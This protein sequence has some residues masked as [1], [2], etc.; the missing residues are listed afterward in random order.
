MTNTTVFNTNKIR[1][2]DISSWTDID[3]FL[4][5]LQDNSP[6]LK[7]F[8]QKEFYSFISTG[9]AFVTYD[10]GI[11]GVSMEIFK[12]AQ[13]LEKILNT[14]TDKIPLHF[15]SGDFY[16]KADVVLKPHWN[17]YRI[18]GMN[19]WS[20]WFDGKW[21][22][23]LFYEEMPEGSAL[24]DEIAVE[25]WHQA[26]GFAEELGSY[27]VKN[28]ISMII[29]V[30]I[31]TNPG[32][33]AIMLAIILV[34]ESL[35]TYIISSNHDYYWEGGKSESDKIPGERPGTRDHFFKNVDNEP[36]FSLF[37]KMYPWNG[38]RWIQ[39]N[40]NT[41][42]TNELV[43]N[44]G[45]DHDRVFELGTAISDAFF[46]EFTEDD[47]RIYRR[48]MAYILSDGSPVIKCIPV[49]EHLSSLK[50]WMSYQHPLVCTY[51]KNLT[52]DPAKEKTIYCLQ[53]TRVVGR[54]RIYMDLEMLKAMIH[55]APFMNVFN[56]DSDYQL[57][58]HITGPVPI[59]HQSDLETVL[60]AYIDLCESLLPNVANRIYLAFSVGTEDHPAL[61]ENKLT[62]LT[63]EQI[64]RMATVVLFPSET[65]GRGLPII[66]SSACGIPIIC[67]RYHPEEVFAEV[68][69]E[70]LSEE[71]QIRYLRFPEE[72]YSERFLN[73]ATE[74]MLYSEKT[75]ELTTHNKKAVRLRYT[76][77]MINAKFE[78]FFNAL[79][80]L[81]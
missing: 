5:N 39:V 41:T 42:Q 56:Q 62:K 79:N 66:E 23:T 37:K 36:F 80:S 50:S 4:K 59:E 18:S 2:A 6:S 26:K 43:N 40:I 21:F 52:L 76:T 9:I 29:P 28:N 73:A 48:K 11:D 20:K 61:K 8:T 22:S 60:T 10:F 75:K 74:L 31:P 16:D 63:I 68:V 44:F 19:G 71:L 32:N 51:S 1:S 7:K 15:I 27:L 67:S 3:N 14:K 78:Q 58:L 70:G 53:P 69:G 47:T 55:H 77:E 45:F 64:Y 25:M 12:Y 54:K 24:S 35:G 46:E 72:D 34:T 81:Q 17:R 57:I 49:R 13:S 33:F 65:E 38:K 30:N